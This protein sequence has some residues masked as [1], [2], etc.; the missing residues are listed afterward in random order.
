MAL[1]FDPHALQMTRQ[2]L[3]KAVRLPSET[4]AYWLKEGLIFAIGK[5]KLG[6]GNHRRFGYEAIHI[7]AVLAELS[8]YGINTSGL[9][10]LSSLLWEAVRLGRGHPK[11]TAHDMFCCR[12]L[13]AGKELAER[14]EFVPDHQ[15][16]NIA[17]MR[18]S[19]QIDSN[20]DGTG[21]PS[22]RHVQMMEWFDVRSAKLLMAYADLMSDEV[23]IAEIQTW[24]VSI[25]YDDDFNLVVE[26]DPWAPDVEDSDSYICL[27]VSKIVQRAWQT[28]ISE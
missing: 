26:S 8:R 6:R 23:F 11:F 24:Y 4:I 16:I 21:I 27:N 15:N 10:N 12:N 17:R 18:D 22:L 20:R 7:A 28:A 14:G 25:G 5:P 3:S 19:S 1:P 2:Q 9:R 13:L